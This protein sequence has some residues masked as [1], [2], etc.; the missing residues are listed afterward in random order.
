MTRAELGGTGLRYALDYNGAPAESGVFVGPGALGLVTGLWLGLHSALWRLPLVTLLL[1][2]SLWLPRLVPSWAAPAGPRP[3]AAASWLALLVALLLGSV[4][5]RAAIGGLLSGSWRTP[6]FAAFALAAAALA[7]KCIGGL[8]SDRLGWRSSSTLA[9]LLAAPLVAAGLQRFDTALT[10]ML[11]LAV[12]H[13]GHTGRRL[14]RSSPVAR[15]GFRPPLPGAAARR[16]PRPYGSPRPRCLYAVCCAP[17]H[18]LCP[19]AFCGVKE[20]P[21]HR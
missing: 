14:S 11:V 7:G 1:G 18:F 2:S 12:Y 6:A 21:G 15:V 9:L 4:A 5:V 17:G 13:A 10:G 16:P 20:T 3:R 19:D 8:W